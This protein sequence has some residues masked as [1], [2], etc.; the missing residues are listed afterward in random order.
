MSLS[1]SI[2]GKLRQIVGAKGLL[3]TQVDLAAYSFDGTSTWQAL[4]EAVVFP[5]T[6][7]QVS[8]ILKRRRS[9]ESR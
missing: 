3:T 4:P 7:E 8:Q 5:T 9:R 6:A 2:L 1:A